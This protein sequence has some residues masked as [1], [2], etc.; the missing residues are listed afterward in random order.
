MFSKVC[1]YII[2]L[3]AITPDYVREDFAGMLH[4]DKVNVSR[5]TPAALL[6]AAPYIDADL[7]S[8]DALNRTEQNSLF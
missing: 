8:P 1:V 6:A 3:A 4:S 5:T 2:I 7:P